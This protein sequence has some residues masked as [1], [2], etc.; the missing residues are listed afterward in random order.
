MPLQRKSFDDAPGLRSRV[1]YRFDNLLARGTWAVLLWLGVVTLAAV[2]VSSGLLAAFGVDF[3]GSQETS[4]LEDFWQSLLRVFDPGTMAADV[5]WGRR[6]LALLVT[7]FGI[8]IAGTL[9]GLIANGV[10]QRVEEMRRGRSTVVETGHAVILGVS[11]RLPVVVEQLALASRGRR[12]DAIVVLADREPVQLAEDVRAA[13]DDLHGSRLVVRWGDPALVSDLE[14]VRLRHARAVIVLADDD[15]DSDGG[16]V[17]AV[18]AA[19]VALGGF[20][21]VPIVAE[22][23]DRDAAEGLLRACGGAVHTVV[24]SESVARITA[25]ALRERGLNQVVEELLDSRGCDLYLRP[26]GELAD[27]PFGECVFRFTDARPIGRLGAAGDVELQPDSRTRLHTTDQLIMLADDEAVEAAPTVFAAVPAPVASPRVLQVAR[28]REHVVIVGWNELGATLLGQLASFAAP[29]SSAEIVHDPARFGPPDPPIPTLDGL[30][31]TLQ[32]TSDLARLWDGARAS[33][34]TSIVLLAHRRGMAPDE[35]DSRTLL[36][37]ML[38]RRQLDARDGAVPRIVVELLNADNLALAR[39]TAADDY[40]VSDAITS[41]LITQLAEQPER[42]PILLSLYAATGPSLRLVRA[43]E[44]GLN[45]E[46]GGDE[47]IAVAY[48]AGLL[49]LGWRRGGDI[50]LNP[51]TSTRV[52]LDDDDQIV[53][54]G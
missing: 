49:A 29:G 34:V 7:I 25:F 44:L 15:P 36:T 42:R 5:G 27:V 51:R 41:R 3:A 40:V 30:G 26:V 52:V 33:Q 53:V 39:M 28:H 16:V 38:L 24:A 46:V 23:R 31:V 19:G 2:L 11:T 35:A 22:M 14:M 1:R 13:T 32:A 48:S 20:D 12:S 4:W 47:V 10:E 54:I 8:L 21:R 18:L 43:D 6:I 37:H 50:V 17:R 9:I 45:G